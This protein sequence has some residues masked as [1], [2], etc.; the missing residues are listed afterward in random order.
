[1]SPIVL[2]DRVKQD[3]EQSQ[4]GPKNSEA[5]HHPKPLL[6]LVWASPALINE[7][8]N[9]PTAYS[10]VFLKAAMYLS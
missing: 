1:M 3:N 8:V 6:P 5:N 2:L 9:H 4:I 7:S 10:L